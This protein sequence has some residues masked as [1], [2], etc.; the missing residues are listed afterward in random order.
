MVPENS[1]V[2]AKVHDITSDSTDSISDSDSGHDFD[3]VNDIFYPIPNPLPLTDNNCLKSSCKAEFMKI[4]GTCR[5]CGDSLFSHET[6]LHLLECRAIDRDPIHTF[7]EKS[8]ED[9]YSL[10]EILVPIMKDHLM[11]KYSDSE[12]PN[13]IFKTR[14][15]FFKFTSGI[16]DLLEQLATEAFKL[17]NIPKSHIFNILDYSCE[18]PKF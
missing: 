9:L 17:A 8:C 12:V 4:L 1:G 6:S 16:E 5:L 14:E 2:D 13:D 3:P 15:Q 18:Q 7:V 10:G 11:Y